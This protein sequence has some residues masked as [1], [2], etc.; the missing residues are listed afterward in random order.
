MVKYNRETIIFY[1]IVDNYSADLCWPCEQAFSLFKNYDLDM[2]SISSIGI[3][4]SYSS[5][6]DSLFTLFK[7]VAKSK[8]C[9]EEE[10]SVLYLV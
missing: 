6:C 2:V 8:I 3:Y 4:N 9:D 5:I 1:A 7:E 10:G